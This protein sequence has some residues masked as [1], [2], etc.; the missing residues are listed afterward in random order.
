MDKGFTG[1]KNSV[2]KMNYLDSI[3]QSFGAK[4]FGTSN[5]KIE[6]AMRFIEHEEREAAKTLVSL[7]KR[8]YDDMEYDEPIAY[9]TRNNRVQEQPTKKCKVETPNRK[10]TAPATRT[11]SKDAIA[12]RT[13]SQY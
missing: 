8:S 7:S 5:R 6:R 11:R 12:Y 10:N 3:L 1:N 9:R 2:I 4:T 13:R